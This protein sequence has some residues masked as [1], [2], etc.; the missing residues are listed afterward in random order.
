M[1]LEQNTA[2]SYQDL[3]VR[4]RL[5]ISKH[6]WIE[7]RWVEKN[8]NGESELILQGQGISG[9]D[10]IFVGIKTYSDKYQDFYN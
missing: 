2:T 1:P 6:G 8:A 3:L 9:Q 10:Q 4:L 5:F 7:K